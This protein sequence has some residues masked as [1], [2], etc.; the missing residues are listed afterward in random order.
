MAMAELGNYVT[1]TLD[2]T[3]TLTVDVWK[4]RGK[5]GGYFVK[6]DSTLADIPTADDEVPHCTALVANDSNI[7][8]LLTS[9]NQISDTLLHGTVLK[10]ASEVTVEGG[11][12]G[13]LAATDIGDGVQ[14]D[15]DG[16][17]EQVASGG[18]GKI[19]AGTKPRIRMSFDA[20]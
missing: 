13:A 1:V 19:I 7:F 8:G 12:T 3:A 15:A 6:Q 2:I 14:G 16:K 10:C 11:A 5:N 18:F 17:V 9:V 4:T 20:R